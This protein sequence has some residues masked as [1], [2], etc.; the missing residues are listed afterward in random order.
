M[1]AE[2]LYLNRRASEERLAA[3]Q[4]AHPKARKAHLD[5]AERYETRLR[6]AKPETCRSNV[7]LVSTMNGAS[8]A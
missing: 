5:L 1:D 2:Y 6:A 4:A 8:A 7:H 3:K